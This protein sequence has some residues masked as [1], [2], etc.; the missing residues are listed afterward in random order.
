[1]IVADVRVEGL[2]QLE[3]RLLELDAIAAK[4]LLTRATRRSLIKLERQATSNAGRFSRSGALAE[5]VRIVTVRPRGNETVAVQVGPKTKDKRA[6]AMHNV[7][8]GRKRRSIFYGHLVEFGHNVRGSSGRHVKGKPWFSS[9][10]GATRGGILQE[11][12]R[13]LR[14]GITRIEKRL[15]ARAAAP[16]GLIDP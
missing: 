3:A 5:S 8:Y 16:E 9:A 2:Q 7:Y 14:E 13:I 12:Q 15:R 10:W 4:R 1:M 6:V 11:F